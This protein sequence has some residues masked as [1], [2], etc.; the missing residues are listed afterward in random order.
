MLDFEIISLLEET[1]LTVLFLLTA[2][3]ISFPYLPF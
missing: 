3:E 1:G 2:F